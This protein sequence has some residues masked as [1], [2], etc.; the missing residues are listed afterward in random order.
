MVSMTAIALVGEAYGEAEARLNCAFVGPSG[1]ALLS[2][3][4][5]SGLLAFTS[6]DRD[7]LRRYYQTQDSLLVDAIWQLHPEVFRTNVFNI[8]PAR[9]DLGNLCADKAFALPGFGKLGEGWIHAKYHPELDRLA[10]DLLHHNPNLIVCLG[11]VALWALTGKVGIAKLRGTTLLSTHTVSGFKLLPTYH[12][13]AILRQWEQRPTVIADL[14]KAGAEAEYPE[15]RRPEREIWIDPSIKDVETFF[16]RYCRGGALLSVDIETSGTRITCIGFAPSQSLGLVIP[17]DDERNPSGSY[18][19]TDRDEIH[20]WRLIRE[21]LEDPKRPKLFH[22]GLFDITF[23]YRS[24]KIRVQGAE[25]D[26]M[27]LHHALQPESLK[28]LGYLA[29]IYESDFAWKGMRTKE[30][31]IKRDA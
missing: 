5:E 14:M 31:T 29:S 21:I 23:L 8:H 30:T 15:I 24:M 22:N 3:L 7:F 13:A 12:P 10:A 27:L 1:A 2:M 17:F 19:K 25:E 11:N 26:S 6:A 18:W 4:S 9:N 16:A 20:I 28:G